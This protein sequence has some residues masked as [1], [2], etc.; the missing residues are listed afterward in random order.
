VL[1]DARRKLR[2]RLE[3]EGHLKPEER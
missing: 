1:H 2:L 3:H